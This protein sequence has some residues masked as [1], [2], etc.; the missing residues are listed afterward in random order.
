MSHTQIV[1]KMAANLIGSEVLKIAGEINALKASGKKILNFTVGDFDPKYFP[2][3]DLLSQEIAAALKKQETNYP[4]SSGIT[5][6]RESVARFYTQEFK[7]PTKS[8]EVLIAGGARV[9]SPT[10]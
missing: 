1:S 9:R 7:T 10:H 4:P 5:E 2:I 3:P 8:S 6:L